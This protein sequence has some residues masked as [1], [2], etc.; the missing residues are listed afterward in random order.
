MGGGHA[1]PRARARSAP[2]AECC[3]RRHVCAGPCAAG[4]P[5]Q[6]A[7]RWAQQSLPAQLLRIQPKPAF[8]PRRAPRHPHAVGHASCVGKVLQCP[9]PLPLPVSPARGSRQKSP[10]VQGLLPL[11]PRKW[12]LARR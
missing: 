7:V 8:P 11:H 4:W 2:A 5:R 6:P 10:G 3:C 9:P 12:F 1:P